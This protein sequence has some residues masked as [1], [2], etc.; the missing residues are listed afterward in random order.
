MYLTKEVRIV[1][2]KLSTETILKHIDVLEMELTKLKR[3]IL[4]GFTVSGKPE[5][6]KA[7]LFGSVR[8]GDVTEKMIE[9]SE[10]NLFRNLNNI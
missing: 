7:S 10:H 8:G 4:R 9:E 3:D 2:N 5:K 6:S 1:A